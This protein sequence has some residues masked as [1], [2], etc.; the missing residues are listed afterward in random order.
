MVANPSIQVNWTGWPF[1]TYDQQVITQAQAGSVAADVVQCPPELA[2]TLI[3]NYNMCVPLTQI[4]KA[5]GLI[6]NN[7]HG[8]FTV[9]GQLYALGIIQVAF[10]MRYDK[11]H[12]EGCWL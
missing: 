3:T 9:N 11:R 2:T 8:Q 4:P 6:P 1:A 7:S 10:S 5:L 12:F